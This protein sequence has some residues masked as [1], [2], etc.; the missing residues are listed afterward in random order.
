[1]IGVPVAAGAAAFAAL[2]NGEGPAS[3]ESFLMLLLPA[4]LISLLLVAFGLLPLWC[5]LARG[6]PNARVRFTLVA[7]LVWL[8]PCG[9]LIAATGLGGESTMHDAMAI[10]VPGLILVAMFGL[11][12]DG[13][14]LTASRPMRSDGRQ[15][16]SAQ[17]GRGASPRGPA[18]AEVPYPESARAGD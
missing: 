9:A 6:G 4:A 3:G 11:L 5:L 13:R 7:A 15:A 1:M 10:L 14:G 2:M 8:L 18:P 17:A 16:L 12:A